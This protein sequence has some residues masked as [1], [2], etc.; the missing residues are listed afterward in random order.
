M[1][2][3]I[4]M[5]VVLIF[6]GLKS[7][8]RSLT[9][10]IVPGKTRVQLAKPGWYAIFYEYRSEVGG[11]VFDT[12]EQAPVM[13]CNLAH[14]DTGAKVALQRPA[15]NANYTMT[16][17]AGYSVLGFQADAGG[18][19][20]FSCDYQPGHSG[21]QVVMAIGT[22]VTGQIFKMV[23][24]GLGVL[25]LGFC[26]MGVIFAGVY[27]ERNPRKRRIYAPPQGPWPPSS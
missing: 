12:G 13:Q 27:R 26:A 25:L 9:R 15:T 19:Y 17:F 10:V 7:V 3:A 8:D 14:A 2:L 22:G 16:R 23:L 4:T 5:F 20:D 6:D 21:E 24:L 1:L 18:D 11:R